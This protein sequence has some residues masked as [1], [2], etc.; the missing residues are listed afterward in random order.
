MRQ[1]NYSKGKAILRYVLRSPGGVMRHSRHDRDLVA[2]FVK[3]LA[4]RERVGRDAR[5]LRWEIDCH[6]KD[7][8]L[9]IWFAPSPDHHRPSNYGNAAC[10]I[11]SIDRTVF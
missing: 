11:G 6:K 1:P 7:L 4:V 9:A 8:Q 2:A 3:N 5:Q 10:V